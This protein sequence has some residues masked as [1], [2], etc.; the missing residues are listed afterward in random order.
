MLG[1]AKILFQNIDRKVYMDK[2]EAF[3]LSASNAIHQ[4]VLHSSGK[5]IISPLTGMR[6]EKCI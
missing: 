4:F 1:A 6:A 5:G 3:H 2:N